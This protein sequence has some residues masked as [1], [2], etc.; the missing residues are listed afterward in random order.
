MVVD[1]V[2]VLP[3]Q[4]FAVTVTVATPVNV[5]DQVITPELIVPAAAGVKLH[6]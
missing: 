1:A 5:G 4:P 6:E 2:E 3:L